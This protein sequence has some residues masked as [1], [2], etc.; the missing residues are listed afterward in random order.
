MRELGAVAAV[1]LVAACVLAA[2][3]IGCPIRFVTGVPCPGCG[4]TR[5]WLA[6]LSGEPLAAFAFH[7]LFWAAPAAVV[8]AVLSGLIPPGVARRLALVACILMIAAFLVVWALRLADPADTGQL[9]GISSG[10]LVPA[11]SHVPV[12]IIHVEPSRA[13]GLIA[14]LLPVPI[15]A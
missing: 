5:A 12:D 13:A 9:A 4:L 10:W 7:P 3:G 6:L 15:P 2:S 11:D 1:L 14:G 8:L